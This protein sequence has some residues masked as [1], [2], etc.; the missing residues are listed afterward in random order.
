ME[1]QTVVRLR[2]RHSHPDTDAAKLTEIE[3]IAHAYQV[4]RRETAHRFW[5]PEHLPVVLHRPRSVVSAR[6]HSGEATAH[7]LGSHHQANAV[8]DGLDVV[9]GSWEQAFR[10]VRSQVGRRA[11]EGRCTDAERHE[12]HWL[13]R[14]PEHLM[15]ILAGG[16]VVP[17]DTDGAPI[18]KFADNDHARL[19]RW[20]GNALRRAR[21]NQPAIRHSLT[22]ELDAYRVSVRPGRFP[23]WLTIQ[24][25][26]PG[27][28]LR[29]P[30]AGTDTEYLDATANLRVGVETDTRGRRSR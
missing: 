23:I 15:T 22:F 27:R 20:L 2:E 1:A 9:H 12:I 28:P 29:I 13:L 16:V 8:L 4:L 25:L 5:G 30:M 19:D 18:E 14:W 7:P 17:T 24:G 26:T 11:H 6:R 3:T 10:L 21:P